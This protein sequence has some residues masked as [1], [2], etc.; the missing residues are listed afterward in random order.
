MRF[1]V[2]VDV[3]RNNASHRSPGKQPVCWENTPPITYYYS[4]NYS[5]TSSQSRDNRVFSRERGVAPK[6]AER[7]TSQEVL[8][9]YGAPLLDLSGPSASPRSINNEKS[10]VSSEFTPS[11]SASRHFFYITKNTR[12]THPH[13][14]PGIAIRHQHPSRSL[15]LRIYSIYHPPSVRGDVQSAAEYLPERAIKRTHLLIISYPGSLLLGRIHTTYNFSQETTSSIHHE[16]SG[17]TIG[18]PKRQLAVIMMSSLIE[19]CC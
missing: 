12:R 2:V 3:L 15:V 5:T 11:S 9:P 4:S 6:Q 13:P 16:L 17:I 7:E 8:P 14:P 19:T 18:G 1:T 10:L